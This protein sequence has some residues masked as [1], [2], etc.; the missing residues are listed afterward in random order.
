MNIFPSVRETNILSQAIGRGYT[1]YMY[2]SMSKYRLTVTNLHKGIWIHLD[3]APRQLE[4]S[5]LT[6]LPFFTITAHPKRSRSL[7]AASFSANGMDKPCKTWGWHWLGCAEWPHD[8]S[9]CQTFWKTLQGTCEAG[10]E[11]EPLLR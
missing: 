2:W 7:L 9:F 11:P 1:L 3:L 5:S 8:A 6:T 4:L 10:P